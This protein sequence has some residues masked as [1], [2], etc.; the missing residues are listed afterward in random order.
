M[1]QFN[2]YE[3]TLKKLDIIIS[4]LKESIKKN[5]FLLAESDV[6]L[7]REYRD[8]Y[9]CQAFRKDMSSRD[10]G[11][12]N[13]CPAHKIGEAMVGRSLIANGCYKTAK[14]R[15]MVRLSWFYKEQPSYQTATALID[16]IEATKK[17]ME[18]YK[19]FL[20]QTVYKDI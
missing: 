20:D 1:Y 11:V 9:Y 10:R 3:L 17:H 8:C 4:K 15:E 18:Q 19:T 7:L 5:N 14:Y 2:P 6:A 13:N 12:C 16:A